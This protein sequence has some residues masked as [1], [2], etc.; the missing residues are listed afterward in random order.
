MIAARNYTDKTAAVSVLVNVSLTGA[1][2]KQQRATHSVSNSIQLIILSLSIETTWVVMTGTF[3][4]QVA[5][6]PCADRRCWSKRNVFGIYTDTRY[7][8]LWEFCPCVRPSVRPS[9][10]GSASNPLQI[11]IKILF[12]HA[13]PLF[14]LPEPDWFYRISTRALNTARY[15]KFAILDRHCCESRKQYKIDYGPLIRSPV[16]SIEP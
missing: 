7:S 12:G 2:K 8:L 9:R 14:W 1:H 6:A 10:S 4:A 15:G 13:G 3:S 5:D 16:Y 11:V